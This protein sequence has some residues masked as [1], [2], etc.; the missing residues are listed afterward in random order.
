M[1]SSKR[2]RVVFPYRSP[3]GGAQPALPACR[4]FRVIA[5]PAS[6]FAATR[7]AVAAGE[8]PAAPAGCLD[9]VYPVWVRLTDAGGQLGALL[10]VDGDGW[11]LSPSGIGWRIE[12]VGADGAAASRF[13]YVVETVSSVDECG[14]V[15]SPSEAP[16]AA[17][18]MV[19]VFYGNN[20]APPVDG[21]AA[22]T[23][24]NLPDR[25]IGLFGFAR[26]TTLA[27]Q[28]SLYALI[29]LAAG[30]GF[31]PKATWMIASAAAGNLNLPQWSLF[32]NAPDVLNVKTKVPPGGT[33]GANTDVLPELPASTDARPLITGAYLPRT[34][35]FGLLDAGSG[36][37]NRWAL[38]IFAIV[39]A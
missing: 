33:G 26:C 31:F 35:R 34:A 29:E 11:N 1:L 23:P 12:F 39:G 5:R 16:A 27:S 15:N 6:D 21:N 38:E 10:L 14:Q 17:N 13:A 24:L 19:S 22:A 7:P 9:G 20:L 2:S 37:G 30:V 25:T 32:G 28:T 18:A 36:M 4:A 3:T 8:A